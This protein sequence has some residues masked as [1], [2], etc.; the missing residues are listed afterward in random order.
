MELVPV[1]YYNLVYYCSIFAISISVFLW[2]QTHFFENQ[3]GNNW[4]TIGWLL[5]V[6]VLLYMGL[7]PLDGIFVDMTIYARIFNR[8]SISEFSLEQGVDSVFYLYTF[9]CTRLINLDFYFFLC[10]ALYIIP[11]AFVSQKNFGELWGIAFL[12]FLASFCFWSYGV[13]GIR[14]GIAG[15][16]FLLSFGVKSKLPRLGFVLTAVG[17][18]FSML[19]PALGM[20]LSLLYPKTKFW[21]LFWLVCIPLSLVGGTYWQQLLS[22]V[23]FGD[24]RTSYLTAEVVEGRFAYIGFRWDFLTYS[25]IPVLTH[26]WFFREWKENETYNLLLNT[27]LFSNAVWILV[28]RSNF[29]NRFAY[30]SWFLMPLVLIYPFLLTKFPGHEKW[31]GLI[32]L[33]FCSIQ[34]LF[35]VILPIL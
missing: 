6:G 8:V 26:L 30:L 23:D 9:A 16:V 24:Q 14:N 20:L 12:F 5:F 10:A 13:N 19:L 2:S 17:L 11:V 35:H 1:E 4:K 21:L 33:G 27:Y 18:H 7:R 25:S 32:L 22:S 3:S 29:S 31:M 15:S 28:I 34:F